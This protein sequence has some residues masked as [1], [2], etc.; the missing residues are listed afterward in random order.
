MP[1]AAGAASG[2]TNSN[3][4]NYSGETT[5]SHLTQMLG[6]NHFLP[7]VA[8]IAIGSDRC[9]FARARVRYGS[10]RNCRSDEQRDPFSGAASLRSATA[11]RLSPWQDLVYDASNYRNRMKAG[12][13]VASPSRRA[14]KPVWTNQVSAFRCRFRFLSRSLAK[15]VVH[16]WPI[17]LSGNTFVIWAF[18]RKIE[19]GDKFLSRLMF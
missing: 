7:T 4:Q 11:P 8:V 18:F 17:R 12:G 1:L 19:L 9:A 2:I 10:E 14:R 6:P 16:G 5:M 13:K 15:P 3:W